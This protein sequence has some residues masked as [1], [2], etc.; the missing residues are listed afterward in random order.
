[1]HAVE[2]RH[3]EAGDL[4]P[5]GVAAEIQVLDEQLVRRID[6]P[7]RQ[8][9]LEILVAEAGLV[10]EV[11]DPRHVV[12]HVAGDRRCVPLRRSVPE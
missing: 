9:Q 4:V 11:I 5:R 2:R 12:E 8:Q 6:E 3:V 1:M 10:E 7:E